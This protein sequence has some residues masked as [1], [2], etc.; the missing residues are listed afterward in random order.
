MQ[1]TINEK[2]EREEVI[3][4]CREKDNRVRKIEDY[5]NQIAVEINVAMDGEMHRISADH[6][7]YI[8]SVDR[9][10][11]LCTEENIYFNQESLC[12]L[13]ERLRKTSIVRISKNCLL[14]VD[15]LKS[16]RPFANHR[17]EATLKNG[18]KLLISRMYIKDL[19]KKLSM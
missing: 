19:K 11:F 17:F 1:V 3:I 15:S 12:S 14:N 13:E 5:V 7:L 9:K 2:Q 4:N 8:E 6:I 16:I 10:T 18:E